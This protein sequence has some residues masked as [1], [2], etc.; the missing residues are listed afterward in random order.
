MGQ[1]HQIIARN[2]NEAFQLGVMYFKD[3]LKKQEILE[4]RYGNCV[5][6]HGLFVT[7]YIKPLERVLFDPHRDC[8][9]FFHI[10]ESLWMLA[11]REDVEFLTL[12]NKNMDSFTDDGETYHGAYGFRWRHT[13]GIDQLDLIVKELT[14][15]PNS[16]RAV[17]QIWSAEKDLNKT[18]KDIPC[19]DMVQFEIDQGVLNMNVFNRSNDMIWGAYG[20][21]A[22]QFSMLQEYIAGRLGVPVGVYNQISCNFH[23]YVDVFEKYKHYESITDADEYLMYDIKPYQMIKD[24]KSF[25]TELLEWFKDPA[26]DCPIWNNPFFIEVATPIYR[27]WIARKSGDHEQAYKELENCKAG[28]WRLA[29]QQWMD[30]RA[31]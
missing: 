4:T 14:E 3:L 29:C 22:V 16:R 8:N 11:G 13:F 10:M 24:G 31:K 1:P 12:F 17:L 26:N 30:R 20:A 7:Q 27:A 23:I 28:D 18:S 21:N 25:D 19:N 6:H 9:P 15:L 5:R 2:V